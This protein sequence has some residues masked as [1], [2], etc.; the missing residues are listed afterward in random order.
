MLVHRISLS[1]L[2][3]AAPI[4]PQLGADYSRLKYGAV[5]AAQRFGS[6][7]ATAFARQFPHWVT[8]GFYSTASAYKQVPTAAHALWRCMHQSRHMLHVPLRVVRDQ[9]YDGEY[10]RLSAADRLQ[11]VQEFGL[12]LQPAPLPHAR[13][14]VVDDVRVTGS[15]EEAIAALCRQAGVAEVVFAYAIDASAYPNAQVEQTLNS[16][17]VQSVDDLLTLHANEPCV[18][19][20]RVAK[21]LLLWPGKD[22]PTLLEQLDDTLLARLYNAARNDGY[23]HLPGLREPMQQAERELQ[24]RGMLSIRP[25]GVG[26]APPDALPT[27]P[28]RQLG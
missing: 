11:V 25:L 14:L 17:A 16:M 12:L 18:L 28:S 22:L 4:P 1:T 27:T 19:N 6:E 24:R 26:A 13:L 10:E 9:V 3:P 21:R 15:H 2:D 5:A 8:Q 7:L 20:A 23:I